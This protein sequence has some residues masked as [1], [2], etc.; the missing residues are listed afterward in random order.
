MPMFIAEVLFVLA[1][2]VMP[3]TAVLGAAVVLVGRALPSAPK[4]R[5][6]VRG[7]G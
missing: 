5:T 1:A 2:V 7:A 6:P 3:A 4:V